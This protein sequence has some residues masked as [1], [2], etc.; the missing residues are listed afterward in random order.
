[1]RWLRTT[2]NRGLDNQLED[3][4]K[5]L[6]RVEGIL[7]TP[8]STAASPVNVVSSSV[9]ITVQQS[10]GTNAVVQ[11]TTLQ[12]DLTAGFAITANSP[13][14][15]ITR[16]ADTAAPQAPG[17]AA[18][19]V[20]IKSSNNDHVHPFSV[21]GGLVAYNTSTGA[22]TVKVP[23]V[24]SDPGSPASGDLWYR[25]DTNMLSIYT[26]SAVKRVGMS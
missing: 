6:N 21:V 26:G 20:A 16:T 5:R 23:M 11:C 9:T 13:Y 10:D 4:E 18:A 22:L 19:G 15:T 3:T 12:V 8:T 2:G 14:A 24:G 1:M 17:A 7:V 25:T